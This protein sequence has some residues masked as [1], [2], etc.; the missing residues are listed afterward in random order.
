MISL[1]MTTDPEIME[2]MI[3]SKFKLIDQLDTFLENDNK[4]ASHYSVWAL[5]NIAATNEV[6][7]KRVKLET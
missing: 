4:W 3:D 6:A 2:Y 7:L 5:T 1:T